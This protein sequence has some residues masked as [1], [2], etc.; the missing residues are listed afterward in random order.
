[1]DIFHSV[2]QYL[3]PELSTMQSTPD[4]FDQLVEEGNLGIKTGEGFYDYQTL[5]REEILRKR[6]L[7]FMRQLKLIR[8]IESQ[9]EE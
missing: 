2:A 7:Y 3:L 5:S 1:L 6:D 8:E 9:Q 4:F